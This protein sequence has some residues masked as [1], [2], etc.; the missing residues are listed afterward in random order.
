MSV[1]EKETM[2]SNHLTKQKTLYDSPLR[3]RCI[4]QM[5]DSVKKVLKILVPF[6]PPIRA[7]EKRQKEKKTKKTA[8]QHHS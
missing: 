6:L 5:L 1:K 3:F 2:V 4:N 8:D 7:T